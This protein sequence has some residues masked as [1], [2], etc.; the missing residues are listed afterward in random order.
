MKQSSEGAQEQKPKS[1]G[2]TVLDDLNRPDLEKTLKREMRELYAFFL[3]DETRARLSRMGT[4]RRSLA[5]SWW[6]L[7]SLILRLTP[8]R[9]LLLLLALILFIPQCGL[10][11]EALR[12]TFQGS[13]L[14][15]LLVLVVLMLELKDKLVAKDELEVGRRVQLAL[16]PDHNPVLAGWEIWMYTRPANDVG[17]DLVDYIRVPAERLGLALGDVSGKGLG[18]ALLMAKLQATLRALAT[19]ARSLA[20]LGSQ[21]NQIF[22]R[23]GIPGRFATLV[24]LLLEPSAGTVQVLNAGH[25]PPIVIRIDSTMSLPAVSV[26]LGMLTDSPY[27]DQ[28]VDLDPGDLPLVYS[29]GLA[30]ARDASGRFFDETDLESVIARLP[31]LTAAQAGDLI[32]K[33][34]AAFMGDEPQYDDLSL[35]IIRRLAP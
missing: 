11:T 33:R 26:P 16:L 34:A 5:M 29:D 24:Y 21:A 20:S 19:D 13:G 17:G 6:L 8:F 9:R 7:K 12:F 25:P 4:L 18:A 28:Q 22:C 10:R 2:A 30:E 14:S 15:I 3:D 31:G 23:D 32:I 1:I 27:Q 35:V